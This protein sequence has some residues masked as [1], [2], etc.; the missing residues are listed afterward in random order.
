MKLK[1]FLVTHG[2]DVKGRFESL[3]AAQ[4]YANGWKDYRVRTQGIYV[5]VESRE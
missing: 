2:K 5:L 1:R 3:K 4:D